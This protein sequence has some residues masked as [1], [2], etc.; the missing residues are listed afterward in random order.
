MLENEFSK[1]DGGV[2][3][4]FIYFRWLREE[5]AAMSITRKLNNP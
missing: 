2:S 5:Q 1:R 4:T 3:V